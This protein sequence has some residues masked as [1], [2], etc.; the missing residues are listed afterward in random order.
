MVS[1]PVGISCGATCEANFE[2]GSK[3]VLTASPAVG[4]A[5]SGWGSACTVKAGLTC[6]VE[7]LTVA[8]T[9][10][11]AFVATPS[12]TIEKAGSGY[13]KAGATG[14]SCDESCSKSSAAI[15][16]GMA[17]TVKTA[18]A[19]GSEVAVLEGGTG[20][21][22]ACSGVTC[23]F[24]IT[25][26]SSVKVKFVPTP[27]KTLTVNL[28][29]PGKY[30]GKVTGKA[31]VK[32]LLSTAISCGSGCTSAVET[33]F[34]A[35]TTELIATPGAGYTFAGW[36]VEGGTAGTC[37]GTTSPCTLLT[38]ADKTVSAKFE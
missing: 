7:N 34:A 19:K 13:G 14:I 27:T 4:Y 9:V 23:T 24:T 8:T 37:T 35:G 11:A 12:L 6:T 20:N 30:K 5:F 25:E 3:V 36:T 38:D 2:K 16:T 31:T 32:G 17:V 33:F 1:N 29:G 21:A 28:T 26:N 18:P 22:S 15:K 10:K